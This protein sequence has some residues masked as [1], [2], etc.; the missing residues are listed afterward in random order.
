MLSFLFLFDL[1][2]LLGRSICSTYLLP[3]EHFSCNSRQCLRVTMQIVTFLYRL[4]E[5]LERLVKVHK[6]TATNSNRKKATKKVHTFINCI[7]T[8]V[9]NDLFVLLR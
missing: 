2:F 7:V 9:E 5:A 6:K 1:C 4:N 3:Y 8:L